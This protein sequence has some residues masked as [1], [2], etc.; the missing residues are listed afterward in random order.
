MT[1]CE[2]VRGTWGGICPD[3]GQRLPEAL[4]W[5]YGRPCSKTSLDR[6]RG[7]DGR[8]AVQHTDAERER[9]ARATPGRAI[10][11]IPRTPVGGWETQP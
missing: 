7:W 6:G 8:P 2:S 10:S 11:V 9:W 4:P 5:D 1:E 3:C